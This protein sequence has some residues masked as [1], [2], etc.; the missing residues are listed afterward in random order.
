MLN[1]TYPFVLPAL[2]YEY[3][4][5]EPYID[6]ETMHYHHDKHF[7]AYIDN[8]NHALEPYPALQ[9]LT[10]RQ[11]LSGRAIAHS[12]DKESIL[13]NAGGVFNHDLFF[14]NLS[15][16][17]GATHEPQGR[18]LALVERSFGSF[19][20]FKTEFKAQAMSVFG[21]GWTMLCMDRAGGL[22]IVNL[23][24]QDT[25][26]S[27]QLMPIISVDVWEHAYYLKYRNLR[28]DYLS[29]VW[30]VIKFPVI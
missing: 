3:N 8:L 16:F 29:A 19:E 30:N 28:A 4:A 10:L 24:N 26:V 22:K 27:L 15:P 14:R 21:S 13:K 7:R 17:G 12:N 5:L 11:I 23:K 20:K 9:K 6:T 18:L 1:E 2:G 25:P